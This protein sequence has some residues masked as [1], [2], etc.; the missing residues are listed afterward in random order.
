MLEKVLLFIVLFHVLPLVIILCGWL[1]WR[2]A[3]F[4]TDATDLKEEEEEKK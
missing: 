3:S 4:Y 1:F 2:I